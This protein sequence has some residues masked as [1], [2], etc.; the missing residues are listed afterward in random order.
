MSVF[1]NMNQFNQTPIKGAVAGN[2]SPST[3]SC[4]IVSTSTNTLVPG[5]YVKIVDG[6]A[7]SILV[8]KAAATD[9]PFGAVV[10]S[11]KKDSFVAGDI[12]E[13]VGALGIMFMESQAAIAR[14]ASLEFVPT[15]TLVKTNAGVNPICGQALDK[16]TG[17]NQV[18][19]VLIAQTI[20]QGLPDDVEA[21]TLADDIVVLT[22]GA[23]VALDPT[24]GGLFQ[25]TPAANGTINAASV[26][27]LHQRI[28]V[29]V[30]TS[31][32]TSYTL[33]FGTNFKSAGTLATG[34][35]T[36]KK[37]MVVFESD[38]T[39]WVEVSRTTAL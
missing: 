5:D 13:V 30:I 14:G 18:I 1:Q 9:V 36:A 11:P 2:M 8:D 20:N 29:E 6:T 7:S 3:V 37:F 27:S 39:E 21:V 4:Q 24:L 19:R 23:V 12:L 26:N 22:P 28:T 31:G 35:T 17:A 38:G 33:T 16:A 32:T 10:F 25:L 34:T 15:G